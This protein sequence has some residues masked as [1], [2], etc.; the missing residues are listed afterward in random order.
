LRRIAVDQKKPRQPRMASD[1]SHSR[2]FPLSAVR[3][4][5]QAGDGGPNQHRS[6][7]IRNFPANSPP[8]L[9]P[10]CLCLESGDQH[11][12]APALRCCCAGDDK[13]APFSHSRS[14]MITHGHADRSATW[15]SDA[16][17]HNAGAEA[18]VIS[19]FPGSGVPRRA[20]QVWARGTSGTS[21]QRMSKKKSEMF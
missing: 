18:E 12:I 3:Q 9:R 17:P 4:S 6:P 20:F 10:R 13:T 2:Q 8:D 21:R 16:P 15:D 7:K 1:E 14:E 11:R 19:P 5:V